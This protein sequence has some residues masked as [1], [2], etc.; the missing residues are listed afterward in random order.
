MPDAVPER[1]L[2][3]AA[4]TL[5]VKATAGQ[6]VQQGVVDGLARVGGLPLGFK[7]L[8]ELLL[9]GCLTLRVRCHATGSLQAHSDMY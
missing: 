1:A 7:L 8:K 6:A 3:W 2:V 4:A 5:W 9:V